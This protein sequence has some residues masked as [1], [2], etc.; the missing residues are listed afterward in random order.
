MHRN[1]AWIYANMEVK[2]FIGRV[3]NLAKIKGKEANLIL[4]LIFRA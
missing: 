4:K 1:T 3:D 2:T